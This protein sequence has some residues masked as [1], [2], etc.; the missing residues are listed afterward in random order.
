MVPSTNSERLAVM[1]NDIKY[2][3][4]KID[5]LSTNVR[6]W[7]KHAERTFARKEEVELLRQQVQGNT[8]GRWIM[9]QQI[10]TLTVKVAFIGAVLVGIWHWIGGV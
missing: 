10:A 8:D 3:K 1:E 6:A 7:E 2:I 4:E 5:D 9:A